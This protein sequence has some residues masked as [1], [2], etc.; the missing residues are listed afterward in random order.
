MAKKPKKNLVEVSVFP[1]ARMLKR[2]AEKFRF[3]TILVTRIIQDTKLL[4]IDSDANYECLLV[5]SYDYC[6]CS[7][8]QVQTAT[9]N[10][11]RRLILSKIL[12]DLF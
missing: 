9:E 4:S 10:T 3:L 2:F 8:L 1:E 5:L 12:I 7:K 6:S 11:T